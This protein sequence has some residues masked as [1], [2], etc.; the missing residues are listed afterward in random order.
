MSLEEEYRSVRHRAAL[1][2]MDH[3]GLV[4]LSGDDAADAVDAICC[5]DLWVR[6]GRMRQTLILDQQGQPIADVYVCPDDDAYVLMCEGLTTKE[7]LE[8]LTQHADPELT[9]ELEDLRPRYDMISLHGPYSWEVLSKWLTPDIIGLPYL[10]F[11]HF[12]HGTCFRA[13]KTGEYGYDLAIR[14]E[15]A[16]RVWGELFQLVGAMDGREVSLQTLDLCALES[17]FFSVRHTP[18]EGLTPLE[19][20]LQWRI[21]TRKSYPGTAAIEARRA[22][23]MQHRLTHFVSRVPTD[24]GESVSGPDG[25]VGKVTTAAFSPGVGGVVGLALLDIAVAHPGIDDFFVAGRHADCR[26]R[27]VSSPLLFNR[28]LL[29][30]PHRH[31]YSTRDTSRDPPLW[32]G[33]LP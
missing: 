20:Q 18:V 24:A 29:V 9:F 15:H 19:L 33:A 5:S 23:S 8:L 3:V 30:D 12:D 17:G 28:S 13:G 21:S 27:T 1:S 25:P 14:S 2:R 7:L 4:R 16:D 26:I 32:Q 11:Y 6:D 22:G 10:S 31:T